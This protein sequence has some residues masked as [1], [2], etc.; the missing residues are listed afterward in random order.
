MSVAGGI[1]AAGSLLEG[2]T[3]VINLG[4][5]MDALNYNRKLQRKVF[6]R[7]DNAVQRRVAD[8]KSAGLSPVLA[9]GSAAGTGGTVSINAPQIDSPAD[10]L[11]MAYEL[12]TMDQNFQK[13]QVD[14][15]RTKVD[16]DRTNAEIGKIQVDVLK[17]LQE[18]G[19]L[20]SQQNY[21]NT[22]TKGQGIRNRQEE[23]NLYLQELTGM[24]SNGGMWS[25]LIKDFTGSLDKSYR[26]FTGKPDKPGKTNKKGKKSKDTNNDGIKP[27]ES[28]R[29]YINRLK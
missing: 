8:L 26:D 2:V 28:I 25:G 1:G 17:T 4:M 12:A 20:K 6:A 21:I 3:S 27:G 5:Q 15:D 13:T 19:V 23:I 22:Q 14:M 24:S 18:I 29:D 9:A 11:S 7:E 16:M 10:K